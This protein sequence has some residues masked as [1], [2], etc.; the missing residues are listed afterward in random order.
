MLLDNFKTHKS[1]T[2]QRLIEQHR[3]SM[4]SSVR[5]TVANG[6]GMLGHGATPIQSSS[7]MIPTQGEMASTTPTGP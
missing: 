4:L 3:A 6:F 2:V 1:P 5:I 7:P